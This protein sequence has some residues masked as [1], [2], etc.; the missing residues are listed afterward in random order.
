[1]PVFHHIRYAWSARF[2]E[3]ELAAFEE[4]SA[5]PDI[6]SSCPQNKFRLDYIMGNGERA[7]GGAV[8]R[9]GKVVA[10]VSTILK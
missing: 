1:M 10:Y 6:P 4:P 8:Y 9:D 5:A 7:T 2:G 3:P